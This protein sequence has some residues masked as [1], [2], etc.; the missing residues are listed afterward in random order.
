MTLVRFDPV[1]FRTYSLHSPLGRVRS[2]WGSPFLFR[3]L[4]AGHFK[5]NKKRII[6]Y[7]NLWGYIRDVYQWP[8]IAE[9]SSPPPSPAQFLGS[10][11][12]DRGAL[13]AT[14]LCC[15]FFAPSFPSS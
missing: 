13:S 1:Y 3:S 2:S 8:G 5:T 11:L 15:F 7:P 6:D 4:L 9:V 14:H 10:P 12:G